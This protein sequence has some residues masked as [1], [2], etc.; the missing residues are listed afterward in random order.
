MP[1]PTW[2]FVAILGV[3]VMAGLVRWARK[4]GRGT[5]FVSS[6]MLLLLGLLIVP[7]QLPQQGVEQ[8]G[9]EKGK[10]GSE[11]GDPPADA[12][13]PAAEP[14]ARSTCGSP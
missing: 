9:E 5:A 14:A 2:T 3:G 11:S 4:G 6:G 7:E 10:K 1:G 13:D 12:A 8:A